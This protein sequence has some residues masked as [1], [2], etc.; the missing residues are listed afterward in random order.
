MRASEGAG[1]PAA[2]YSRTA[3]SLHAHSISVRMY[4]APSHSMHSNHSIPTRGPSHGS[5]C[6]RPLSARGRWDGSGQVGDDTPANTDSIG[7][8]EGGG[9]RPSQSYEWFAKPVPDLARPIS[10]YL[11]L[12]VAPSLPPSLLFPSSRNPCTRVSRPPKSCWTLWFLLVV[13]S[14]SNHPNFSHVTCTMSMMPTPMS[15]SPWPRSKYEQ[16]R[17]CTISEPDPTSNAGNSYSCC[18]SR[19]RYS[20][21]LPL[22][23]PAHNVPI[24]RE[25]PCRAHRIL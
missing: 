7:G 20:F 5:P 12:L 11:S 14:K 13:L 1:G 19:V 18:R 21:L 3:L 17:Y 2:A 9:A 25:R 10:P 23:L 22:L 6:S 24:T 4:L 15:G 8:K 16:V